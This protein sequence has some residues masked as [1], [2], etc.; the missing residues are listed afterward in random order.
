PVRVLGRMSGEY[1]AALRFR[2]E[3]ERRTDFPLVVER[4]HNSRRSRRD[5][6]DKIRPSG[7]QRPQ[8]GFETM[9][10]PTTPRLLLGPGPSP[11]SAR[12]MRALGAP[13]RSHLDPDLVALLDDIRTRTRRVFRAS[14]DSE[15][16]AVSGTG[17]A[18]MEAVVANL[19]KSGHRALVVVTGYFGDRLAGTLQRH[20]A[21][22]DRVEGEWG[23][24]IDPALVAD[25]LGKQR[26]DIVGVV[27]AETS[28]GVRNPVP[29]IA[30]AAHQH[31]ALAIVDAV[32]SLG[33]MP[34][35]IAA[36]GI[37]A[38]YSCSQKGLGAPAGMAPVVFGPR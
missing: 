24:A 15:A 37:D 28:T 5:R 21:H 7:S 34:L 8:R 25:A 11:V 18:G 1:A 16:L 26:Y 2:G 23:R 22:V 38:C 9:A 29:E 35:E 20:G 19:T 3:S 6:A 33:A 30:A 27:H 17:S 12:V 14:D 36:W 4:V 10:L 32:T 31:D 13:A